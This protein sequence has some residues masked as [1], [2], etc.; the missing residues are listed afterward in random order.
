MNIKNGAF[1]KKRVYF[2]QVSNH[3]LR[4]PDLSLKAKGLYSLIQSY[5]TIEDFI[6]YKNTLRKQCKEGE[7]AFESAW[8]ELKDVGYLIQYKLKGDRGEFY[9]EYEL[10]DEVEPDKKEDIK[11]KM[12]LKKL[13]CSEKIQTYKMGDMEKS[14]NQYPKKDGVDNE[15]S[16][17]CT[18]EKG[19]MYNN[20]NLTNNYLNNTDRKKIEEVT[21]PPIPT[22]SIQEKFY[23]L[24]SQDMSEIS[25]NTWIKP[26]NIHIDA[27]IVIIETQNN[28]TYKII[29]ERYLD[30]I[31]KNFMQLRIEK[32]ILKVKE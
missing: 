12:L 13:E 10:V 3:A 15:P 9:Y 2:T 31:E 6:L 29:K 30:I 14:N 20:T 25:L 19:G 11:K 32:V 8:K 5:L 27:N 24:M 16:G 18:T 4:D 22:Q 17:N 28:F 7:K 26:L 23:D 21:V 1:R